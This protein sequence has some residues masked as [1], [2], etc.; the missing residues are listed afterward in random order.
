[1]KV[2]HL[3]VGARAE[4]GPRG[5]ARRRTLAAVEARLGTSTWPAYGAAAVTAAYGLLKAYWVFGGDALWSIAP[6]APEMIDDIRDGTAPTWFV[7]AD[8][9]SVVLAAAGVGFALAT[10]RVRRWLPVRFVRWTLLPL[11]VLMV[12]LRGL[13]SIVGD[14]AQIASGESGPWTH[15][16]LWD[17]GLW[18]PLFLVW[19]VLWAGTAVTYTRRAATRQAAA[20]RTQQ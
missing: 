14:V 2:A 13:L 7:I 6:L 16:A 18:S 3:H 9:A 5:H 1:M 10:L 11:A 8:A 19:G 15:T 17:L 20:M 4:G 12:V